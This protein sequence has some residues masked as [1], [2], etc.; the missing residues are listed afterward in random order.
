MTSADRI[1]VNPQVMLGKPVIRGA[2]VPVELIP[3]KLGE[4][5]TIDDLLDAYPR[6]CREDVQ[7]ALT[8]AARVVGR[9]ETIPFESA[10]AG[11]GA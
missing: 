4:G 2:R 6:L 10:S 9:E 7:A 8:Y 3:R 11:A 1:E 5:A